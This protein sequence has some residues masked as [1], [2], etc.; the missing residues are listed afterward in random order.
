MELWDLYDA[1]HSPTGKTMRRGQPVPKGLY[2]L[3]VH[4]WI[5]NPAGEF[6]IQKRAPGVDM[7]KNL[8]FTTGGSAVTGE[9]GRAAAAREVFEE[10]G[11]APDMDRAQ[12]LFT[13]RREDNFSDIWLIRQ[14]ISLEQIKMQKSEV[15]QVAWASRGDIEQLVKTGAFVYFPYMS[16]VF[17]LTGNKAEDKA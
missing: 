16:E 14:E 10:L 7:W 1:Q 9:D 6:L 2:H 13:I 5:V 11:V 3:V 4:I 8:W 15:S 12:R 17:A